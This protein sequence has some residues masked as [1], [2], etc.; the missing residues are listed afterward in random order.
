M[1]PVPIVRAY[2]SAFVGNCCFSSYVRHFDSSLFRC[3]L[4]VSPSSVS[5]FMLFTV[6]LVSNITAH[7]QIFLHWHSWDIFARILLL[8]SHKTACVQAARFF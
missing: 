1:D 4:L 8:H 3:T 6:N 7:T 2:F 5:L